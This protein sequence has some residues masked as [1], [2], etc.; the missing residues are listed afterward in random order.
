LLGLLGAVALLAGACSGGGTNA[1]PQPRAQTSTEAT[2]TTVVSV[3]P[4]SVESRLE[5]RCDESVSGDLGPDWRSQTILLGPVGF[6]ARSYARAPKSD[7][8]PLRPG[9]Y[10]AQKVLLLVRRATTV[11]VSVV[12]HVRTPH[13]ALLY[14]PANWTDRNAYRVTDGDKAM[15]FHACEGVYSVFPHGYTQFNGGFV[16]AGPGC[17][18]VDIHVPGESRRYRVV[19]S[20]GAGRCP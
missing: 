10:P 17:V 2:T 14:N 16:V 11:T 1:E 4:E 12:P 19:L 18:H 15:T 8:A 5:R 13:A 7:F 20:F 9:R 3:P 6:V